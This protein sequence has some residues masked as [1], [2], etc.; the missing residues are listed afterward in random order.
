MG[1]LDYQDRSPYTDTYISGA[2]KIE[3][4]RLDAVRKLG[5]VDGRSNESDGERLRVTGVIT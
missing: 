4:K 5:W 2:W 1:T 3:A